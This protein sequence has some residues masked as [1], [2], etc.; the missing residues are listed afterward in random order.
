MKALKRHLRIS[1][2]L[3]EIGR[4]AE[5]LG[6]SA[7]LVGGAVRDMLTGKTTLDWDITVEGNPAALVQ[8]L[9]KKWRGEIPSHPAFGTFVLPLPA[10]HHID[11]VTARS[12][13]YPCPG[14]LPVVSFSVLKDDL[15]RRDFTVNALAFGLSGL[16]KGKVIDFYGGLQDLGK[17]RLRVLHA[18][19]FQDDPTRIFRL[20]RFAGRGLTPERVTER[21]AR[22]GRSSIRCISAERRREELIAILSE[23]DPYP[24]LALLAKWKAFAE[25]L[26]GVTL[27]PEHRK[28]K[29]RKT[30]AARLAL[31]LSSLEEKKR[32]ELLTSLKLPHALKQEV[33][34]LTRPP[35]RIPPLSGKDL[36]ALGYKPGPLFKQIL[37][38]L[39][40]K[41]FASR[42]E[43]VKFVFD[44]YPEKR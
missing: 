40:S 20:A 2:K 29:S 19:S 26:P 42:R 5:Q 10:S 35:R 39:A 8:L 28:L 21:H 37:E 15:F 1:G 11:F 27:A 31:L 38:N 12:E 43:A 25:V 14:H 18:K 23:K 30:I 36:I 24:A 6:L 33:L 13:T 34:T 7:Y 32:K 16:D 9:A 22:E 4:T 44:K 41:N 17:G 3:L